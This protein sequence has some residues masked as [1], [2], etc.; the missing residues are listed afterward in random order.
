MG[1]CMSNWKS[2]SQLGKS[3]IVP[4]TELGNIQAFHGTIGELKTLQTVDQHNSR[5]IEIS[6]ITNLKVLFTS[7]FATDKFLKWFVLPKLNV[8]CQ[9]EY[10]FEPSFSSEG[11]KWCNTFC[12]FISHWGFQCIGL[13]KITKYD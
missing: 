12:M 4:F 7:Y 6:I 9:F 8:L 10:R 5:L 1:S 3:M 11:F 2:Y 13:N